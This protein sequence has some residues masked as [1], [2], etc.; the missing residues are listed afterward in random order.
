M[1]GGY[2]GCR[3]IFG[4]LQ[5]VEAPDDWAAQ[6]DH[7]LYG[8]PKRDRARSVTDSSLFLDTLYVQALLNRRNITRKQWH[9]HRVSAQPPTCGSPKQYLSRSAMR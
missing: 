9:L 2:D 5:A 8:T 3:R 6:H 7:Y 1:T 4:T